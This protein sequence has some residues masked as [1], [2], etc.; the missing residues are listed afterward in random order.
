LGLVGGAGPV[1][2]PYPQIVEYNDAVQNPA[3]VFRDPELRQGQ[4][5]VNALGLPVALSGGFALTYM[6]ATPRRR[7]AVRCFHREIPRA[8]H[9]YAAIAWAVGALKIPYFV[10]FDYLADG[11]AIRG[12]WYPVVK[13]DWAEGDPL[14]IWLDRNA[15]DRRALEKLR[16]EFA[17]LAAYL[18]KHGIAHGDIQNGNVIIS[19]SG[20]KLVDYDGVFVPGMPA[21]FTSETGHKHFQHPARALSHF[22]PTIDRFSFIAV[23]LSLAAL[24]QDPSLH[25]RFRQGGETILFRANDFA[26]PERSA[27]FDILRQHGHLKPA[28]ERFAAICRADIAAVPSLVDFLAGRNIQ[29]ES[30]AAATE[31]PTGAARPRAARYI[32]PCPVL[33]ADDFAEVGGSVGRRIELVGQV[34]K[35]KRGIGERGNRR[36]KPCVLVD[37]G[38]PRGDGVRVSVWAENSGQLRDAPDASWVGRWVSTVGLV[39]PPRTERSFWREQT[40][41]GIS[42]ENPHEIDLISEDEARFRL[43]RGDVPAAAPPSSAMARGANRGLV[44]RLLRDNA[45]TPAVATIRTPATTTAA[46]AQWRP[47]RSNQAILQGLQPRAAAPAVAAARASGPPAARAQRRA[48]RP[49][50]GKAGSVVIHPRNRTSPPAQAA[51]PGAPEPSPWQRVLRFFGGD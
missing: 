27:V 8:Q 30:A 17:G 4:V 33:R 3:T 6:M 12:G 23:D 41:L 15:A 51:P 16:A 36:G 46:A 11:I 37:F 9:K 24:I 5:K 48:P 47:G 19:P 40:H 7:L 49:A 32:G 31:P 14:G 42:T 21:D 20:L 10:G 18:E 22:G 44:A 35:V 39:E 26:D 29:N 1:L 2:T 45:A 25:R 28:A 34:R 38:P 43:R 13:M 50:I